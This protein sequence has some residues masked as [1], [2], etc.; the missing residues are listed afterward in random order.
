MP[1]KTQLE[2]EN[3]VNPDRE[4]KAGWLHRIPAICTEGIQIQDAIHG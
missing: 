3:Q 2:V 4:G 1:D